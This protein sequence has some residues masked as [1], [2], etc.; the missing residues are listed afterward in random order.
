MT[1]KRKRKSKPAKEMGRPTKYVRAQAERVLFLHENGETLRS[2][3]EQAGVK[4]G[5]FLGWV[6]DDRDKLSDRYARAQ[7]LYGET[8]LDECLDIVDDGRNDWMDKETR[9]GTIEVVNHEHVRRSEM[10]VNHRRWLIDYY[11]AGGI[12]ARKSDVADS[13]TVAATALETLARLSA[14]KFATAPVRE[15]DKPATE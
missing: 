9:N 10:R 15:G 14:A 12:L 5:T 3:C 11:R 2:S 7:K 6:H 1:T 4:R 13:A 8:L